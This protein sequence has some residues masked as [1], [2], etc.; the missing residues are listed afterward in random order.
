MA[1]ELELKLFADELEDVRELPEARRWELAQD[2]EVPLGV[3]AV[4]HPRSKPAERFK[5]RIRWSD[6]FGP[7][8]LKFVNLTTGADTDRAA[9][10]QCFGF[11]PASLDACLPWTEEGHRL[12]P[13][14][15]NS[16]RQ[17]FP[18]VEAPLQHALLRLQSSL[19]NT[20]QGRG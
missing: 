5:A 15:K 12:H 6:Y 16:S 2:P 9:W 10:P 1:T 8:S 17:S 13:E 7:F 18:S 3:F 11:R 14:W 20:Y 4:M 19:D